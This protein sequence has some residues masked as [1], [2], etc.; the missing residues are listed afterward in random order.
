M[1]KRTIFTTLTP[2]P[3]GISR[4]TVLET[5]H[6]HV[7]MI[8]LNPL[9]EERHPIKPPPNATAE[10]YH[11]L[12]YSLT[13]KVAYLPGGMISGRVSYNVC[14]HDLPLGLQTHCYAPMGLNIRG[15][16]TLGGSLPGEPVA[17]VELG[18][19]APL[20][21]LHIRE[22]VDMKCNIVM[23]SFVKKTLKKAHAALVDRLIVKSQIVDASISNQHLT[24]NPYLGAPLS[25]SN[26]SYRNNDSQNTSEEPQPSPGFSQYRSQS[27]AMQQGLVSHDLNNS[28][29]R[30]GSHDSSLY[31]KALSVRSSSSTSDRASYQGSSAGSQ[32]TGRV[33][34]QNLNARQSP[35]THY[36]DPA[37]QNA[38]PYR[39]PQT[40]S[41]AEPP[42]YQ[43]P[44]DVGRESSKNSIHEMPGH[45]QQPV[46]SYAV[47]L[48]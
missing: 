20:T 24:Q 38:N 48:E 36:V 16:W 41:H 11:C 1:S 27:P 35:S 19:G 14:F 40:S 4:E 43:R 44:S 13:D 8:D 21:G 17:P 29:L 18:F 26:Y 42:V 2:L 37:Y 7:E 33:S 23:T 32:H 12:W 47:E 30:E 9:V 10:E 22:D 5:L 15:K 39:I 25:S 31:P 46:P 45:A 6:S 3:P 28:D 34:W